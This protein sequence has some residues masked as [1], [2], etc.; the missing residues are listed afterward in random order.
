M[1][2]KQRGW[3]KDQ[4][5][6]LVTKGMVDPSVMEL[7]EPTAKKKQKYNN[8]KVEVD[9]RRF[10]SKKEAAHYL[11]LRM[12]ERAGLISDLKLQVPFVLIEKNETERALKY[13]A[14]FTYYEAGV[15]IVTDVK[16]TATR[17]LS[18]YVNKRK[19]MLDKFGIKI[20]EV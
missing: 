12:K 2:K 15:Y 13:V 11:E 14:D 6:E 19:L 18:T 1:K 5:Q 4:V 10:D 17:K 16:S 8:K 20:K 7:F 9:G 3:T